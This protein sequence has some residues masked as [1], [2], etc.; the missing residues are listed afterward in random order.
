[1]KRIVLE[2]PDELVR[3]VGSSRRSRR[4]P[5]PVTAENLV[6]A[7]ETADYHEAFLFDRGSVRVVS[8]EPLPEEAAAG[9]GEGEDG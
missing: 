7:L 9:T 3:V 5:Q 1:M 2:V 8:I 4:I 6:R